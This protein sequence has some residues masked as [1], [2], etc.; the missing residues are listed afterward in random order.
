MDNPYFEAKAILAE[1]SP[2]VKRL[3]NITN[4]KEA[5][6]L[7]STLAKKEGNYYLVTDNGKECVDAKSFLGVM[8]FIVVHPHN[9]YI[10]YEPKMDDSVSN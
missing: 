7:V 8:Y 5:F 3:I 9:M 2:N 6:D 4:E 1:L 10:V